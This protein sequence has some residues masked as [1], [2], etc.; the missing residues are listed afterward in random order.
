MVSTP[1]IAGY[2]GQFL[3]WGWLWRRGG[4][5]HVL[6]RTRGQP[7]QHRDGVLSDSGRR[8][9]HGLPAPLS[10]PSVRSG[11]CT[12]R[13]TASRPSPPPTPFPTAGGPGRVDGL[14]FSDEDSNGEIDKEELKNGFQ[15]L[16]I[17]FTEEE[18]SDLFEACDINEDERD[19]K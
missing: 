16:E 8:L 19:P 11:S 18:I 12:G 5:G 17:S 15:K 14:P 2:L 13:S 10:A 3:R 6:G 4:G 7:E 1:S 9:R